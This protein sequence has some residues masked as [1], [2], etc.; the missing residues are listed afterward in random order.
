MNNLYKSNCKKIAIIGCA[1]SGKTTLALHLKK[2]FQL[3]I[4]HLDQY[5]WKPNWQRPNIEEFIQTH[6][7]LCEQDEWIIDGIYIRFLF[8][9]MYHAD[10]IIF[11]DLPR[12]NCMWNI[13][14]RLIFYYG[15]VRPDSADNCP[16]RFD[17]GFLKWVWNFN[18]RYRNNILN[19]LNE[20]KIDKQIYIFRSIKEI[21]LFIEQLH[22]TQKEK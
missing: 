13:F 10:M 2:K 1:G 5:F 12:Y 14:K 22:F 8:P 6:N 17:I 19:L 9:R 18:K 15:K 7:E 16:E 3:P 11:L 4:Y 20:F 21:N